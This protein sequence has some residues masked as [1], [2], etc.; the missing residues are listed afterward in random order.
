M[1]QQK[2]SLRAAARDHVEP[3]GNNLAR[4]GHGTSSARIRGIAFVMR[5]RR[6]GSGPSQ[7]PRNHVAKSIFCPEYSR[8]RKRVIGGFRVDEP[9]GD[10]GLGAI[11]PR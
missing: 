8:T 3:A 6:A 2:L 10:A 9:V 4:Q 11:R 1:A 5:V 7:T